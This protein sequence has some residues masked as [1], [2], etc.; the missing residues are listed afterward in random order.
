MDMDGHRSSGTGTGVCEIEEVDEN[1]NERQLHDDDDDDEEYCVYVAVGKSDTSMDALSW[2]LNNF[3]AQSPS[4]IIYL[5]HVFPQ[6]NHIPNPLGIGMIPRN[7]VSAE[8]VES[9]IDQE[10]GKR[11]ELLQKFL[12]SCSTSKI[13]QQNYSEQVK[14]DTILIESDSVAKAILDLIPIL[15]IKRLVIGANKLHLRKSKSRRGKGIADQILQNAPQSC[16]VRII[17]EKKEV[18]EQMMSLSPFPQPL[19]TCTSANDASIT[20]KKEDHQN[21]LVSCICFIP[22]FK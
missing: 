16:K 7:Q 5:I 20:S 18:N 13:K 3:V 6:I 12:Q 1:S 22:K 9:Y 15:Q 21:D 17:C 14:V 11:R 19:A 8:Q 10:R 2:A 4:T